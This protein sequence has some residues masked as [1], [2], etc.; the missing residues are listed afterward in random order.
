VRSGCDSHE[1]LLVK[2]PDM[3]NGTVLRDKA[4]IAAYRVAFESI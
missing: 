4:A 3:I 1:S 2:W